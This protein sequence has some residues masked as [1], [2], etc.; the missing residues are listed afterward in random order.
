MLASSASSVSSQLRTRLL[1]EIEAKRALAS[2]EP[3]KELDTPP[4]ESQAEAEARRAERKRIRDQKAKEQSDL[5][6]ADKGK[7]PPK[8]PKKDPPKTGGFLDVKVD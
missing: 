3:V 8:D 5:A 6:K 2:A 7:D 4:K 1:A